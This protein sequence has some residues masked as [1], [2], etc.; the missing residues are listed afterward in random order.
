MP[1]FHFQNSPEGKRA[2]EE[3]KEFMYIKERKRGR[4]CLMEDLKGGSKGKEVKE[5]K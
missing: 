3:V 5:R 2:H 1:V 4:G